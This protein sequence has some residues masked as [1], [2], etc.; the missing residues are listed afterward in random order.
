MKIESVRIFAEP[1]KRAARAVGFCATLLLDPFP[2]A[3]SLHTA[4]GT[5]VG[6]VA[7]GMAAARKVAVGKGE[8]TGH[9]GSGQTSSAQSGSGHDGSGE[10]GGHFGEDHVFGHGDFGRSLVDH[11][12]TSPR[13]FHFSPP[14][15]HHWLSRS[16][17]NADEELLLAQCS[18]S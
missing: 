13:P 11:M 3:I 18:V 9:G 12:R 17:P 8:G 5:G 6:M 10:S 14:S 1:L 7:V 15:Y 4:V 2:V 16:V